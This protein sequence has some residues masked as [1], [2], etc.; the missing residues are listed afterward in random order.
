MS[1]S[2]ELD[3]GVAAAHNPRM[4]TAEWLPA[5][6][7][8][9]REDI[10][11]RR[12]S[13]GF[14]CLARH[15][16]RLEAL[17]MSQP[18]AAVLLGY[19][20]QWVD[21]GYGSPDL[22]KRLLARFP[23]EARAGLRLLDYLH[24]RMAEGLAAMAAEEHEQAIEHFR[25]VESVEE[26]TRDSEL[27]AI[28]NFWIGRC[29]RKQGRYDDALSYTL[30]ARSLADELGFPKMAA[31]MRVLESWLCFQKGKLQ[32]AVAILREAEK[33]LDGTDDHVTLGNIHS[34]YG[35]IAR[36]EGRYDRSLE[37]F[38]A[39]IAEYKKLD[40]GHRN[41]ARSLV[42]IAFVKRLVALRLER[43]LD[44]EAAGRKA[45]RERPPAGSPPQL[46]KARL[47]SLRREALADLDEALSI[48][49]CQQ[50]HRGMGAAHVNYGLLYL[51][52][53]ELDR[54]GAEAAEA[55]RLGEE[56]R[57]A[58]LMGRARVLQC[59]VEETKFEEQIEEDGDPNLHAR[60][61]HEF[62]RDAVEF[63]RQT[64]NRRLLARA[65]VWQGLTLSNA[66]FNQ[67]DE[68]RAACDAAAALLRPEPRDYIWED[69][70]HLKRR[71]LQT[72]RV[73]TVL[74]EWSQ[75]LVGDRTFQQLT[76]DFAGI[77]IPRV[78]ERE[79]RKIS[80][81]AARLSMSP[82]K[83]RRVLRTQGLLGASRD[84]RA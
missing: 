10:A 61:A 5:L 28:S 48:Y 69:F 74:R 59:M 7:A 78:W 8:R 39:A 35:R 40:A 73:D 27:L 17:D 4:S 58:I 62:A 2:T 46:E 44:M 32:E 77:I 9:L 63:A 56:K 72:G 60:R 19:V 49:S 45:A 34:A 25:F 14:E 51:D 55:F 18:G 53:G 57:D 38:A 84:A 21:I 12:I 83:I 15:A 6:V 80:R 76:E 37:H 26:E 67:P 1:T 82:K 16:E 24:L 66:F 75:G 47:A 36:R 50:N 52:S 41:L 54:A 81:V 31:V 20:A 65:L 70:E 13:S 43:K 71:I 79:E 11:E 30:T 33:A 68:A 64:Q 42:N 23:K 22:V 29:L 3:S